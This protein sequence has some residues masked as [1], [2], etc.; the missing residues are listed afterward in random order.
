MLYFVETRRLG[1]VMGIEKVGDK[2]KFYS[3]QKFI[4][5]GISIKLVCIAYVPKII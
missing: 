3:K 2:G 1:N 4:C 5:H